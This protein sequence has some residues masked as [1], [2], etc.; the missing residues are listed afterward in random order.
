SD[1]SI[2]RVMKGGWQLSAGHSEGNQPSAIEDMFAFVDAGISTFDC[3]DI[4]TGVEELIGAFRRQYQAQRNMPAPI[5]IF[6]KYVPD[7]DL[8]SKLTKR[9]VEQV[10]DRSLLRL[11]VNQLDMVQ[12]SWWNYATPKWVETA[13][14]LQELQ[15]A[16]KIKLLGG[17]NFNT[18]AT[19]AMLD[20]GVRLAT[21]QVQYSLLDNRPEKEL[22]A[23]CQAN[24]IK[25]VCYGTVAGGFLS[26]H[27]LN[28]AEPQPPFENRSLIKY[29][30]MIDEIGGWDVFQNLLAVL[31]KI[32][33]ENQASITNIA[34]RYILQKPSVA[35][36]IVGAR[37][38]SHIS[39]NLRVFEFTLSQKQIT[40]IDTALAVKQSIAGDVFDL[41][42]IKDGKH[43]RIMRYNL[44]KQ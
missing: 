16:G 15:Q 3:A 6:T 8:L 20:A 41:E 14:W 30:L 10:I 19:Q 34:T 35:A 28:R 12:F 40:A 13:V 2:S 21:L 4:Y 38:Q 39:D 11:G 36:A 25:L 17:T 1:F 37:N 7:Y 5:Q 44:S 42:R 32:A 23:L 29:K 33:L 18:L 31:Q 27:W 24:K 22:I 43:G 26:D 9:N